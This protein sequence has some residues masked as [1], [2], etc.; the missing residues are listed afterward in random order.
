MEQ[1]GK[2]YWINLNL[3]L[4]LL[5][6]VILISFFILSLYDYGSFLIIGVS[7]LLFLITGF[8][9]FVLSIK[10][11]TQKKLKIFLILTSISAI[12][13]LLFSIL[14]NL[15]YALAEIFK[16]IIILNKI[17]EFLHVVS[18]LIS[19]IIAPI[20]FLISVITSIVLIKNK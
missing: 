11:Q 13:P 15:F 5:L 12:S 20:V 8:I 4:S 3:Y 9:L 6:F 14:H 16:N 18:F 19:I 17:M 7:G 2:K 10:F 1:R